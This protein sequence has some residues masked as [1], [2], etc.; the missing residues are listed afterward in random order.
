MHRGLAEGQLRRWSEEAKRWFADKERDTF[1]VID[2][3]QSRGDV[4]VHEPSF[5]GCSRYTPE[6]LASHSHEVKDVEGQV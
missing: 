4:N 3:N 5:R 2:Y 1:L 6:Y